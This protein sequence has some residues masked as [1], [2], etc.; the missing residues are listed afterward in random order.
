[1]ATL[2]IRI[3]DDKADRL[4]QLAAS[5]GI[6]VNKLIEEWAN[7]GI[8]EFDARASFLARAARGSSEDGL[9]LIAEMNHREA[10]DTSSHSPSMTVHDVPQ[11]PFDHGGK[12]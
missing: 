12:R 7:M 8:A 11:T 9:Q 10:Q 4:K 3:P 2:T 5:R 1:M 6:S